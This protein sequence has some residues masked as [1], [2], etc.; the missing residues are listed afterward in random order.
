MTPVLDHEALAPQAGHKVDGVKPELAATGGAVADGAALTLSYNELLDGGSTPE[1]DDFTVAGGDRARTVTRIVVRGASV[2][3][4]LDV[5]VEHGEAGIQVSYTPGMNPIRDAVGNEAEGLS[6]VPVTNETPDT[7]APKVSSLTI[8][9]TSGADQTYA[10]ED[11][12]EVTVRFSE[13]VEVEGTPAV[14]TESG[15]QESDSQLSR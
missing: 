2:E 13:T 14:D 12:I 10:V 9:S 7:T 4:T 8:S 15:E 1:M 11:E 3:L 6:R 5:G